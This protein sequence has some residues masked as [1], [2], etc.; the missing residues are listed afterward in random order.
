MKCPKTIFILS[1]YVEE[2]VKKKIKF[3][4]HV[5]GW[6]P[7]LKNLDVFEEKSLWSYFSSHFQVEITP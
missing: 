4:F 7:G 5:S 2:H 6:F 1:S 3:E